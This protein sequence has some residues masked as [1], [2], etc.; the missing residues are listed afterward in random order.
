M[1][2]SYSWITHYEWRLESFSIILIS[3]RSFQ[4]IIDDCSMTPAYKKRVSSKVVIIAPY[5]KCAFILQIIYRRQDGLEW[6]SQLFRKTIINAQP[7]C[8]QSWCCRWIPNQANVREFELGSE[9]NWLETSKHHIWTCT[10]CFQILYFIIKRYIF[11]L[12][13]NNNYS[14]IKFRFMILLRIMVVKF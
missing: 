9:I 8:F 4:L 6:N 12:S 7:F 5:Q 14:T 3:N 13:T 1:F 2:K 10:F 11:G